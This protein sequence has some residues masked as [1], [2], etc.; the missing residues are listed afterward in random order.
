MTSDLEICVPQ[1][2]PGRNLSGEASGS[3]ASQ[4]TFRILWNPFV[5]CRMHK[6][7]P[8]DPALHEPNPDPLSC[9]KL[10]VN[11]ILLATP[12]SSKWS[13]A[14]QVSSFTHATCPNNLIVLTLSGAD[15]K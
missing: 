2:N 9:C 6:S 4:R 3:L 14:L 7:L 10:H 12:T 1:L 5:H 11:I 13:P 8:S 15:I